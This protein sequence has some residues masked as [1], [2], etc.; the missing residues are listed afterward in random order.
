MSSPKSRTYYKF[1]GQRTE[2]EDLEA[3][4]LHRHATGLTHL[5]FGHHLEA[6]YIAG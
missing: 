2:T 4:K 1:V 6:L 3:Y 5:L